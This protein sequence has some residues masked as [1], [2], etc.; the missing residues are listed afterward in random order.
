MLFSSILGI[1]SVIGIK[2]LWLLDVGYKGKRVV[3]IDVN[4]LCSGDLEN[5]G[6]VKSFYVGMVIKSY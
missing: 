1:R 3:K 4:V 6:I 5:V 2:I